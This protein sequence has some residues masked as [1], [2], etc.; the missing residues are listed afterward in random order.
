MKNKILG[1][2]TR[3][4]SDWPFSDQIVLLSLTALVCVCVCVCV[5]AVKCATDSPT[6]PAPPVQLYCRHST[7]HVMWRGKMA[8]RDTVG[9]RRTQPTTQ[10]YWS[11]LR[12]GI[13]QSVPCNCYHFIMY[14][15]NHLSC[16]NFR[17]THQ[18]SLPWLQQTPSSEFIDGRSVMLITILTKNNRHTTVTVKNNFTV[19]PHN[20]FR[21]KLPTMYLDI[22]NE[23]ILHQDSTEGLTHSTCFV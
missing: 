8:D 11:L 20:R 7:L 18:S 21:L 2:E 3:S 4:V 22:G 15:S 17:F 5:C 9:P 13:V 16:N 10:D 14:W 12:A 23:A 1:K 19:V 6:V